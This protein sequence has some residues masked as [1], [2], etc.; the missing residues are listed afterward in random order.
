MQFKCYGWLSGCCLTINEYICS[1]IILDT[2]SASLTT[3]LAFSA[4]NLTKGIFLIK[5]IYFIFIEKLLNV[6]SLFD[7][8][9]AGLP[10]CWT[11]GP[12]DYRGVG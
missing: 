4:Q 3:Y 8:L 2:W 5:K 6:S 11:T 12:S 7:Y 1:Y 10:D 9:T